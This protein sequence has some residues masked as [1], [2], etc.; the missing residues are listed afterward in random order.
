[1][2]Q[3]ASTIENQMLQPCDAASYRQTYSFQDVARACDRW[4]KAKFPD[5]P[6]YGSGFG[7]YKQ[8]VPV[9]EPPK[10]PAVFVKKKRSGRRRHA[11]EEQ[12]KAA[13]SNG[14]KEQWQRMTQEE[15][16]ARIRN[17]KEKQI[18][19]QME[20]KRLATL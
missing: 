17:M 11:T 13:Q 7:R 4:L 9:V 12:A 18:Q 8:P 3:D 1:M 14:A 10:D 20:R 5:A 15:R 19:K 6:K 16:N 2:R